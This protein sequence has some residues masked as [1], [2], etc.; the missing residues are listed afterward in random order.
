[1][2]T[3]GTSFALTWF[4]GKSFNDDG[5]KL[6]HPSI[7]PEM[8]KKLLEAISCIPPTNWNITLP[9]E[10]FGMPKQPLVGEGRGSCG[11]GV[12]LA[13]NDF[14]CTR[15]LSIP[16]FQWTFQDMK[17]HRLRLLHQFVQWNF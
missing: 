9:I 13:A 7:M 11:V 5:L 6:N 3:T 12:T 10:H 14:F 16:E 17:K 2:I 15:G 4:Q 8:V 1:M